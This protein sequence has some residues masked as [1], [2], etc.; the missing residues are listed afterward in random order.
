MSKEKDWRGTAACLA[1]G[2][3][4][5]LGAFARKRRR[6]PPIPIVIGDGSLFVLV[7]PLGQR[8]IDSL[9]TAFTS[10]DI[11]IYCTNGDVC[12]HSNVPLDIDYGTGANHM[13]FGVAQNRNG[14]TFNLSPSHPLWDR[15]R[16][17]LFHASQKPP[18]NDHMNS[19]SLGGGPQGQKARWIV[20]T[21][22]P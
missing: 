10:V 18:H 7:D 5:L 2:G 6:D 12:P 17:L 20:I 19:V 22:Q 9:Q 3:A 16:K 4:A 15:S 14:F 1:I 11:K 8:T 21:L 13:Q